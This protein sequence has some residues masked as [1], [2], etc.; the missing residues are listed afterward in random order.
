MLDAVTTTNIYLWIVLSITQVEPPAMEN[1]T[2]A[3]EFLAWITLNDSVVV[4]LP[5]GTECGSSLV[6][7]TKADQ[8]PI[9]SKFQEISFYI[10][11]AWPMVSKTYC[12]SCWW[13]T[14]RIKQRENSQIPYPIF[15]D[16]HHS[17]NYKKQSCEVKKK[18]TTNK[19]TNQI[20]SPI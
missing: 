16:L 5:V 6:L 10:I 2:G 3:W 14:M 7:S 4:I 19:S 13:S 15:Q 1:C 20:I 12:C 9:L 17:I 11:T 8:D 18:K